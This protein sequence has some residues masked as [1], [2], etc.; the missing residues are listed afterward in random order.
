MMDFSGLDPVRYV[1]LPS[2]AWDS[3]LKLTNCEIGLLPEID[4]VHFIESGL[5]GGH[6]FINTRHLVGN[7]D[8]KSKNPGNFIFYMDTNNL[9]GHAQSELLPYNNFEWVDQNELQKINW[10]SLNTD[11]AI[12]YILEVDLTYPPYLHEMHNSFPLA[13][14]ACIIQT[15][16]LSPFALENLILSQA[17]SNYKSEKL[18]STFYRRKNYVVHLKN[19]QLYI[20]QGMKLKKVWRALKFNQSNFLSYYIDLCTQKRKT[21]IS[22]FSKNL[23]KLLA[24]SCFGKTLQDPRK[25]SKIFLCNNVEKARKQISSPL[26]RSHMIINENL[27]AITVEIPKIRHTKPYAIGYAVLEL[28]KHFMYDFY[29]NKLLQTFSF[30]DIDLGFSDTDSLC[31]SLYSKNGYLYALKKLQPFIDFSNY[32]KNHLFFSEAHKKELGYF[33]DELEGTKICSEFIGLRSK[34]YAMKFT[35]SN[36]KLVCKGLGR[37][38]IKN[39]LKFKHYK[40]CLHNSITFRSSFAS[41]QS[42]KHELLTVIRHKKALSNFDTKRYIFDCGIHST[43][44]GSCMIKKYRYCYKCKK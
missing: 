35:G 27:V 13:P 16:N 26:Y 5:R 9:Y 29:Y 4:M 24:N 25:Y 3:M 8:Q 10:M 7:T 42:K 19:L 30:K 41:F 1:S 18:T 12:G 22:E 40:K 37:V 44:Y 21:S 20:Q 39:R 43:P 14:E 34:V 33:K 2:Y 28:S 11:D 15:K 17:S 38:A 36:S 23:Y 32:P 6:S 31:F